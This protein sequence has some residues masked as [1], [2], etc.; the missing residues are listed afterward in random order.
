MTS[1]RWPS[2]ASANCLRVMV[3]RSGVR[4]VSP[5]RISITGRSLSAKVLSTGTGFHPGSKRRWDRTSRVVHCPGRSLL[6]ICGSMPWSWARRCAHALSE[7]ARS[8]FTLGCAMACVPLLA[9]PAQITDTCDSTLLAVVPAALDRPLV[10]EAEALHADVAH[11]RDRDFGGIGDEE[12][13]QVRQIDGAFLDQG[14][15]HEVQERLPEVDTHQHHGEAG[16]LSRLDEG[17]RLRHLVE[18]AEAA[19]QG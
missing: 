2:S 4:S 8:S 13:V 15:A 11:V 7:P 17:G 19:G 6:S 10:G 16:D 5:G 18:G 1:R 3:L 12:Q 14:V 9:S